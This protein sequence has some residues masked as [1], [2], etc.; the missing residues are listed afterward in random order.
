MT[1]GNKHLWLLWRTGGLA[2][3]LA[4]FLGLF[5]TGK[6]VLAWSFS[7]WGLMFLTGELVLL[8]FLR[9]PKA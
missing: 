1:E 9:E 7:L 3:V 2:L 6:G 4:F 5:F 8:L